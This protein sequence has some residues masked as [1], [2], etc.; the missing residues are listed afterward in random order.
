MKKNIWGIF[1]QRFFYSL[2]KIVF[3]ILVFCFWFG[4]NEF[5][6]AK[7]TDLKVNM[8]KN[9]Q[10]LLQIY[11]ELDNPEY[12]KTK[13]NQKKIDAL[14]DG[15]VQNV[16]QIP[17]N[18]LDSKNAHLANLARTFNDQMENLAA[19]KKH[20]NYPALAL[21]LKQIHG[22][23]I[24]C[25]TSLDKNLPAGFAK[26]SD[27]VQFQSGLNKAQFLASLGAFD[28]AL[29]EIENYLDQ[30]SEFKDSQRLN[31]ALN[32]LLMVTVKKQHD[33]KKTLLLLKKMAQKKFPNESDKQKITTLITKTKA[34]QKQASQRKLQTAQDYIN[35][36]SDFSLS[37][38]LGKRHN[39]IQDFASLRYLEKAMALNPNQKQKAEIFLIQGVVYSRLKMA[40]FWQLDQYAYRTCIQT[41]PHSKIAQKCYQELQKELNFTYGG[42]D[43]VDLPQ[44]VEK[45][46][47]KMRS[48]AY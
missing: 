15:L 11:A 41:L 37:A 10:V 45:Q 32:Y 4:F 34:W 27:Q 24:S 30:T 28:K 31:Q 8:Q 39:Q 7:N 42:S 2:P 38:T 21:S 44:A 33:P 14:V 36:A 6:Q 22:Y 13:A 29:T 17:Q 43:G 19:F 48:L 46:L 23:C 5:S 12:L 26:L 47:K 40:L 1:K 16:H 3:L 9:L 35:L 18:L 25:H 20:K